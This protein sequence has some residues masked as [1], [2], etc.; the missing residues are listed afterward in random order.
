VKSDETRPKDWKYGTERLDEGM[1]REHLFGL[2]EEGGE[3]EKKVG[4]LLCGPPGL[5]THG[6]MPGLTAMGFKE[7]ETIFGF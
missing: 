3:G 1:M 4:T 5:I 6:A 2:E 7:D